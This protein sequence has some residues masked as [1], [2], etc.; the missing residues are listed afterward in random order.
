MSVSAVVRSGA[1]KVWKRT[2]RVSVGSFSSP[3]AWVF[4]TGCFLSALCF[5]LWVC[6]A[7]HAR[8]F[9]FRTSLHGAALHGPSTPHRSSRFVPH[10]TALHSTALLFSFVLCDHT[11]FKCC[12]IRGCSERWCQREE[13]DCAGLGLD[14]FIHGWHEFYQSFRLSLFVVFSFCGSAWRSS[15]RPS[16][17][18]PHCTAQHCTA[19]SFGIICTA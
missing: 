3:L 12:C 19:L 14:R 10:C 4:L 6:T 11:S 9:S 8:L 5:P 2:A 15:A 18:I 7:Q 13:G 16:R 1:A 17:F